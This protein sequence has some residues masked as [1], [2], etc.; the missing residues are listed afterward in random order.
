M[1]IHFNKHEFFVQYFYG[2]RTS[3]IPQSERWDGESPL[4]L[5]HPARFILQRRGS[6]IFIRDMTEPLGVKRPLSNFDLTPDQYNQKI[7][8][9]NLGRES[10]LIRPIFQTK[11]ASIEKARLMPKV[12]LAE[13]AVA[14][15]EDTL[16]N[17]NLKIVGSVCAALFLAVFVSN[18][19]QPDVQTDEDLIPK[20]FAKI[21]MTKPKEKMSQPSSGGA[22]ASQAQAKAVARAM[23]SKTV[24]KS[25]KAI[26]KGGLAK[27]SVMNTGRAIQS[28]SQ[29]IV[30]NNNVTG[31]GLQ[32]KASDILAGSRVGTF[33]IG[34]ENGYGSGNGVNV[35]GQG[36]GQFEIGL[37]TNE[38]SV[39]EGL[40]R[41]EV[42]KVIHSHMNDIRYCY[43]TGILKDPS[44][45]GKALID[46]KINPEGAVPN[47]KVGE[48]TLSDRSVG[49]CLISKLQTWKFPKPRGGVHVAVSYPFVFK[50]LSR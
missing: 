34:S 24:Q 49:S 32:N 8:I 25:L 17:K 26:L 28:L 9:G 30:S 27:Y 41:E 4:A 48:M 37:N 43:E 6:R 16:F 50:S 18:M 11:P 36:N 10:L 3:D 33:Q 12:P 46:F 21:I 1:K 35:K 38:A 19:M 15:I 29:K 45:A 22:A 14:A 5:G 47:A 31:A 2:K 7:A 39:D 13:T 23:Q 44:L 20:K 40:T 42:A